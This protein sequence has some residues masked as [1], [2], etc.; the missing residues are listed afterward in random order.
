MGRADARQHKQLGRVDGTTAYDNLVTVYPEGLTTALRFNANS[1]LAVKENAT[2]EDIGA[3]CEVEAVTGLVKVGEGGADAYA[4]P[5]I[6]GSWCDASGVGMVLVGE[7][8]VA[9][10]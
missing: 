1:A 8:F 9:F 6:Q 5:I 4:S 2:G 7:F 10:G 3:N